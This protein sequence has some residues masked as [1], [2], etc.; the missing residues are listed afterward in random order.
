[1]IARA[2]RVIIT[3]RQSFPLGGFAS[4]STPATG[5]HQP[6]EAAVLALRDEGEGFVWIGLDVLA[7]MPP[8]R[9]ALVRE[10]SQRIGVSAERIIVVATHTHSGPAVWHGT[11]HPVLP[12]EDDAEECARVARL[13]GQAIASATDRHAIAVYGESEVVGVGANRHHPEGPIDRTLGAL[14]LEDAESGEPVA[15]VF[16]YAC[17]ATVL[18]AESTLYS[19]DWVG[20]A[21][22]T[23]REVWGEELP[24][25]YLPGAGGDVSTRFARRART[26]EEA[27]RM[28]GIVGSAVISAI[29]GRGSRL[30]TDIGIR[31]GGFMATT[32][33]DFSEVE[34]LA[35]V[36]AAAGGRLEASLAEGRASQE[37][38]LRAG[39]AEALHVPWSLVRIG[40]RRWF[41][42]PFELGTAL[43]SRVLAGSVDTRYVGYSDAY[44]GYLVDAESMAAGHYEARASFFDLAQTDAIVDQLRSA[45][46]IR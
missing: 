2:A 3:P 29:E 1:M 32:R 6:L 40:G 14:L 10:V 22:R 17:H 38:F 44:D 41:H 34:A 19:P 23:V 36:P 45:C 13:V 31:R 16:D 33:A 4:R 39:V 21:R 9:Q 35:A 30:E 42:A 26:P 8:L 11:I 28:G 25:L 43:A 15:A 12:A 46:S 20:G 18:G 7:V 24:V 37:A 5:M 27:E